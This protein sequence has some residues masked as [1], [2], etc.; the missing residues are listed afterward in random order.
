MG[1]VPERFELLGEASDFK[2]PSRHSALEVD[3]HD[4]LRLDSPLD[5]AGDMPGT[6]VELRFAIHEAMETK[7]C[8]T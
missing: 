4:L 5:L 7:Q 3:D 2:I 6:G 1:A 8:L